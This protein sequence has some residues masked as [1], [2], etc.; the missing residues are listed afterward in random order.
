MYPANWRTDLIHTYH[1]ILHAKGAGLGNRNA[2][3]S[4]ES[5]WFDIV[6]VLQSRGEFDFSDMSGKCALSP[7]G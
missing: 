6:M 3:H 5:G 1:S 4:G 7:S 2:R